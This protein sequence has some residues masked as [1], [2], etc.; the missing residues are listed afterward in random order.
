[1]IT[2]PQAALNNPIHQNSS[3]FLASIKRRRPCGQAVQLVSDPNM[4]Q[5][6]ADQGRLLDTG[7]LCKTNAAAHE[8]KVN[9]ADGAIEP[10]RI[11]VQA[12]SANI[13]NLL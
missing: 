9:V 4:L 10:A 13:C 7:K 11:F 3:G 5:D 12:L 2:S 6:N 1:V 8:G